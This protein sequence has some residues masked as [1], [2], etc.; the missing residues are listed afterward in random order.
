MQ[1]SDVYCKVCGTSLKSVYWL[2]CQDCGS[3][4][5][6]KNG[7]RLDSDRYQQLRQLEIEKS[8]LEHKLRGANSATKAAVGFLIIFFIL[9]LG[10]S[11]GSI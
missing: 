7:E 3:V 2:K 10:V 8:N 5:I 11:F 1:I 9:V 4:L 6:D